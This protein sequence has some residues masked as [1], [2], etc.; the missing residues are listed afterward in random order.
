MK[1]ILLADVKGHGKKGD[2]CNV[3]DGYARNFLFPKKLATEANASAMNELKS[4]EAA[5]AH[6]IAEEKAAAS[7]A[8]A[9]LD[10]KTLVLHAK[11]GASGKLFGAVTAKE[12]AATIREQFQLDIDR[13]KISMADIKAQGDYEA[14]IKLYNGISAK[15]MVQ[16]TD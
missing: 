4:R 6:H 10:G 1:V 16:V 7:A 9:K 14:E 3:S 5:K 2:L 15:L 12:V 13:R 11:A 8:A